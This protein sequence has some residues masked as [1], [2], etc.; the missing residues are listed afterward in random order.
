MHKGYWLVISVALVLINEVTVH[1]LVAVLV[2]HYNV[3]DGYAVAGRYFALGSFLF[4]A[5][6][7]ALPYL[8]LVPV[9]VISGLHYTVQGKSALWSALVAVAGIHFWGYWD[10]LEPLYTAEHAS[11]TAALAIVFVPIHSVW[12]G[13][14]AGLLAFVLVKAGLLMFKR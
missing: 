14:L 7:R 8:I 13:A 1:W 3:D 9:A 4:S 10:M 11:S 2:G 12:M 6:F 5:A